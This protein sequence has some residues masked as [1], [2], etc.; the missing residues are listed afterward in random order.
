MMNP[1]SSLA[2][3]AKWDHKPK[4]NISGWLSFNKKE[5]ITHIAYPYQEFWCWSG[6]NSKGKWGIFPKDFVDG[7]IDTGSQAE[8]APSPGSFAT[9]PIMSGSASHQ[10]S[11]KFTLSSLGSHGAEKGTDQDRH[12][13]NPFSMK[14]KTSGFASSFVRR[15]ATTKSHASA[16]SAEYAPIMASHWSSENGG[17]ENEAVMEPQRREPSKPQEPPKPHVSIDIR[18]L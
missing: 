8:P 10:S 14:R 7:L 4:V 15:S 3:T 11:K 13:S 16:G 6:M 12:T 5:R 17:Q 2:A 18:N 9:S 1:K